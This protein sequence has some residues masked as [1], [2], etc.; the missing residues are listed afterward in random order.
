[1]AA[2]QVGF[3][4]KVQRWIVEQWSLLAPFGCLGDLLGMK[5]GPQLYGEYNKP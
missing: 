5:N 2:T 4:S 3:R 1:M